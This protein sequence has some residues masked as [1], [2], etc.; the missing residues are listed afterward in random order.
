MPYAEIAAVL[1][2]PVG[3]I[4]SRL[5]RA[6]GT[7]CRLTDSSQMKGSR[8][9]W[10]GRT[11]PAALAGTPRPDML[12]DPGRS[13]PLLAAADGWAVQSSAC[14]LMRYP[15]ERERLSRRWSWRNGS[16]PNRWIQ[17][18]VCPRPERVYYSRRLSSISFCARAVSSASLP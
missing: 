13:E 5:V 7:F 4:G 1:G 12:D 10:R 15:P 6:R 14:V 17:T 2:V 11:F 8:P 3:T 16:Y 9:R 18:G